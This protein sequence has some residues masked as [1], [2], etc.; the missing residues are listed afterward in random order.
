MILKSCTEFVRVTDHSLVHDL[1]MIGLDMTH[2]RSI[3]CTESI[4]AYTHNEAVIATNHIA[5]SP[6]KKSSA[7]TL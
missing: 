3:Y 1:P 2:V 6:L 5:F 7:Y 4:S